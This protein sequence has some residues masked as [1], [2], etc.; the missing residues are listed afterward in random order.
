[1]MISAHEAL[2]CFA[3]FVSVLL[4]YMYCIVAEVPGFVLLVPVSTRSSIYHGM[5]G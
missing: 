3:A 1:M 5:F 2:R 4:S